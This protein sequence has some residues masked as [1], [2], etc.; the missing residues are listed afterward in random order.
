MA[1]STKATIAYIYKGIQR[2]AHITIVTPVHGEPAY[3]FKF[4]VRPAV[5]FKEGGKWVYQGDA[6]NPALKQ[7]LIDGLE[8]YINKKAPG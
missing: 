3:W 1:E 2:A 4:K 7:A 8:I 6:I 5:F